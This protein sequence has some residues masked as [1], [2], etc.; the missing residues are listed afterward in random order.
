MQ[1]PAESDTSLRRWLFQ[2]RDVIAALVVLLTVEGLLFHAGLYYPLLKPDSYAGKRRSVAAHAEARRAEFPDAR[3]VLFF[4]NSITDQG[5]D[6]RFVDPSLDEAGLRSLKLAQGGVSPRTIYHLLR[7]Q[8]FKT[9]RIGA[10]AVGVPFSHFP[11]DGLI[12]TT[13]STDKNHHVDLAALTTEYGVGDQ[14]RLALSFSGWE[15]RLHVAAGSVFKSVLLRPDMR[16]FLRSPIRRL[17]AVAR[18]PDGL[19]LLPKHVSRPNVAQSLSGAR[20]DGA[21]RL[22]VSQTSAWF[23]RPKN[24]ELREQVESALRFQS[25]HPLAGADLKPDYHPVLKR[26]LMEAARLASK[27]GVP[28]VWM[29]MPST[30]FPIADTVD[31]SVLEGMAETLRAEGHDVRVLHRP[32][33]L[34][35]LQ[36]PRYFSDP[37]HLSVEGSMILS[38]TVGRDLATA[39]KAK[40]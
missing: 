9:G 5:I 17:R 36:Q 24:L 3:W 40:S 22:D 18:R 27:H 39:F 10:V 19:G 37:L 23:Q 16:D 12:K 32:G 31:L 35:R 28:T 4:G 30:P 38:Q 20:L 15:N 8:D 26:Y 11:E 25:K 34:R 13:W 6:T 21:G 14:P 1:E 33:L 2:F 29:A 7:R